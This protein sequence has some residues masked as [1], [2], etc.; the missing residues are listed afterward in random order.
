MS[1]EIQADLEVPIDL[2]HL[3]ARLKTC[4][5]KAGCSEAELSV[6]L[7]GDERMAELNQSYR[8]IPKTTD[9]LSFP[10]EEDG[11][12][13]FGQLLGDIVI[14]VPTALRQATEAG[15]ALEKEVENLAFHGLLHL[16]GR[17]HETE[18]WKIWEEALREITP[19][20]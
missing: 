12:S 15:I 2:G 10:L 3:E 17:D 18:G 20:E 5:K 19:D 4:L 6:L 13:P 11:E 14:S 9:V 7:T 8:G 16:F 1:V